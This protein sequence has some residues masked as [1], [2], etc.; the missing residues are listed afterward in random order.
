M[1]SRW[2]YTPKI[3]DIM[4]F[5][6]LQYQI[7]TLL[8]ARIFTEYTKHYLLSKLLHLSYVIQRL[9]PQDIRNRTAAILRELWFPSELSDALNDK[10]EHALEE[11]ERQDSGESWCSLN[12]V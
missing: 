12:P 1:Q 2:I 4:D 8:I 5:F 9:R 7:A 6:L 10:L 11:E 3:D